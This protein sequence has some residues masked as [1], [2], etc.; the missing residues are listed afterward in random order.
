MKDDF[1]KDSFIFGSWNGGTPTARIASKPVISS[2]PMGL[3]CLP[4]VTTDHL[5]NFLTPTTSAGAIIDFGMVGSGI[6]IEAF[7]G[8]DAT[9]NLLA[10]NSTTVEEFL[11]VTAPGIASLK[12]SQVNYVD[13]TSYLIDNF[14]F[15]L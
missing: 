3:S 8:P 2:E 7:D 6:K 12:F 10:S 1:I 13:S 4:Y 5:I 9:G 11:G 15:T 14:T